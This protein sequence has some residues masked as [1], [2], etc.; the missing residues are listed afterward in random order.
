MRA[1]RTQLGLDHSPFDTT[2]Q[3]LRH[4]TQTT[5]NEAGFNPKQ[6]AQRGGHNQQVMNRVYVHRTK[7]A[8]EAMSAYV[9]G[10]LAP[11]PQ[12]PGR[13]TAATAERRTAAVRKSSRASERPPVARRA[14]KA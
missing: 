5:L 4:W 3:A 10:L 2:L 11:P 1:L 12:P 8:A 14:L 9:G 6:V 7:G 13:R